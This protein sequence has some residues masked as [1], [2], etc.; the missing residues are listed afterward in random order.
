MCPASQQPS[1]RAHLGHAGV[2]AD[3]DQQRDQLRHGAQVL[4]AHEA[5]KQPARERAHEGGQSREHRRRPRVPP[6][7]TRELGGGRARRPHTWAAPLWLRL[8]SARRPPCSRGTAGRG[9]AVAAARQPRR[10]PAAAAR[11]LPPC[12]LLRRCCCRWAARAGPARCAELHPPAASAAAGACQTRGCS[13]RAARRLAAARAPW[14]TQARA[15]AAARPPPPAWPLPP[16]GKGEAGSRRLVARCRA[17][18]CMR[19]AADMHA[20]HR[21]PA[22][23]AVDGHAAHHVQ[24]SERQLQVGVAQEG[25]EECGELLRAG[26]RGSACQS[27]PCGREPGQP[28]RTSRPTAYRPA[29]IVSAHPL[30]HLALR[31]R[32]L[33]QVGQHA[34]RGQQEVQ[35]AL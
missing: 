10:R 29:P 32:V 28:R 27:H 24:H 5:D 33:R 15:R 20:P 6:T 19:R 4:G 30:D 25:H 34:H 26:A 17:A 8:P 35:L 16:G 12:T 3:V 18:M 31:P 2:A 11:S 22:P 7:R 9:P 14:A 13:A 23:H 21:R 1:S